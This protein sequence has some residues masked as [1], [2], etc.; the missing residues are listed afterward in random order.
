MRLAP[1]VVLAL[2]ACAGAESTN[3][4]VVRSDSAG[5][6]IVT[7]TGPDTALGWRFDTVGVLRDSLGEPWLFTNVSSR[8]VITD[9][10]GR[11]YVLE[12]EPAIRRFGRDGRYEMS[13]GRRGGAPGEMQFPFL[14]RQQGD[15]LAVLDIGKQALVRWG[16]EFEP[17]NDIR[18]EGPFADASDVAFRTGGVWIETQSANETE[19]IRSFFLDTGRTAPLF[20]IAE[21]RPAM[22]RGECAGGGSVGIALPPFFSPGIAFGVASGRVLANLGPDY[23]LHL[24]EGNRPVARVRRQLPPRVPSVDDVRKQF[25]QGFKVGIPGRAACEFD[26]EHVI[27]QAGIA[28]Q[29][30]FVHGIALLSDGTIWVQRSVRNEKPI[31]LDVFGSDGAYAGTLRGHGLPVGRLPSGEVLFPIDDEDSG[32]VVVARVQITR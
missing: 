17:L 2:T 23:D 21:P 11:T 5:V 1:L 29:M 14:L 8:D 27:Q 7:S 12:R 26:L 6:R 24:Y 22:I 19:S 31:V 10:A 16:P 15:S 28:E 4:A 25:P 30:P 18:L 32:G 20:R 3:P 13:I 9:R